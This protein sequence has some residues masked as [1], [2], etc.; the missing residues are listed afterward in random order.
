MDVEEGLAMQSIFI[1]VVVIGVVGLIIWFILH[2]TKENDKR[3]EEEDR[4]YAKYRA[5]GRLQCRL[6][7]TFGVRLEEVHTSTAQDEM[8]RIV[9]LLAFFVSEACVK[10]E[11][12]SRQ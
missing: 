3:M 11:K 1:I 7:P 6:Y 9:N 4:N 2:T 8:V 12:E 10:Q 5:M